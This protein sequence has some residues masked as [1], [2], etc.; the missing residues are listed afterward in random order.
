MTWG[1]FIVEFGSK[2]QARVGGD[3]HVF[4]LTLHGVADPKFIHFWCMLLINSNL[5]FGK[6]T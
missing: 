6:L 5:P 3:F 2:F 1:R 4:G